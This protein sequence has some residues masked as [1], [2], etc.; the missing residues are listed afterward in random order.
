ML[1]FGEETMIEA[2][3]DGKLL[4]RTFK[5]AAS[6]INKLVQAVDVATRQDDFA[7]VLFVWTP[8]QRSARELEFAIKPLFDVKTHVDEATGLLLITAPPLQGPKVEE[9]LVK[10]D[11]KEKP[12]GS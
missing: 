7:P 3:A 6:D 9:A 1:G 5:D 11:P 2:T 12:E 4:I 8:R 10:L